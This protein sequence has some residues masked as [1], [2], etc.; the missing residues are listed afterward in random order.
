MV[1]TGHHTVFG[2]IVFVLYTAE[3]VQIVAQHGLNFHQYADDCQIYV[4]TSVSEVHSAIDQFS[5]CLH[6]VVIWMSASRL[7]LNASKTQVLWL[8]SRHNIDRLTVREVPVLS[9]TVGVVGSGRDLGVVIDSQ[10]SMADHVASVCRSEYYHLRQIRPTLQSLSR[11]AAKT[12]VQA[13]ISSRLDY[14]NSVLYGVTDNLVQRL[15][16]VQNAAA[17]LITRTGRREHI[18]P[19]LQELHWLPVRRRVDF[20][21]F[22][23]TSAPGHFGPKTLRHLY[24]VPKCPGHFGTGTEM[25]QDISGRCGRPTAGESDSSSDV[26]M[27]THLS[28]TVSSCFATLRQLRSVRRSTSQAVLRTVAGRLAG[29]V[30]PGLW[31]RDAR[32]STWQPARQTTVCDERRCMTCLLCAEVRAHHPA[33]P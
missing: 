10:L 13:F 19:V 14:C 16:S 1:P 8:G 6:D 20:K 33:T 25:S 26:S 32:R 18:S 11:D 21:R 7:R 9:S 29:V 30:A 23:D 12:V 2:P 17:R 28:G 27:R 4:A 15:Q 3:I 5:R 31:Q 24:L 22:T